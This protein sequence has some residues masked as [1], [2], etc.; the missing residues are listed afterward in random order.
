MSRA[1]RFAAE[2]MAAI[3]VGALIGYTLDQVLGTTPWGMILLLMVGF[4]AGVLNVV[5]AAAE[6]N[7]AAAKPPASPVGPEEQNDE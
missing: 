6:Q 1:L 5:R 7:A 2:F 3:I 4:A